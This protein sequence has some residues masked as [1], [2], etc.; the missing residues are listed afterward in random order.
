M[1]CTAYATRSRGDS[2]SG[3]RVITA[4]SVVALGSSPRPTTRVRR[5]RSVKM[6]VSLPAASTTRTAAW[7][8]W[9]MRWA[10]SLTVADSRRHTGSAGERM[11]TVSLN[12]A[13]L[14]AC[15][16]RLS[17]W[18][19]SSASCSYMLHL[20]P[21]RRAAAAYSP[22]N[23]CAFPMC[24]HAHAWT[25]PRIWRMWFRSWWTHSW[26]RSSTRSQPT[27]GCW[28]PRARSPGLSPRTRL[29]LS[30]R[31]RS[32]SATS[33]A[34]GFMSS[35]RPR[36][37]SFWSHPS[38]CAS[39]VVMSVLMRPAKPRRSASMMW[40]ITSL[41]D[42]SASPG[43]NVVTAGGRAETSA[44]M[45]ATALSSSAATSAVERRSAMSLHDL[46]RAELCDVR[47]G[48]AE[49][50]QDLVRVLAHI[51]G[52]RAHGGGRARQGGGRPL[53]PHLAEGVMLHGDG[54][55]EMLHLL[56]LERLLDVQNG[57]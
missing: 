26:R 2:T 29:T 11:L 32:S 35:R 31:M 38:S 22:E 49:L 24:G 55:A 23:F 47:R 7:R 43:W 17:L 57:T 9:S 39:L 12:T 19:S 1:Q 27:L 28:P 10:A 40:P 52:G 8:A 54:E 44:R 15:S 48:E 16:S 56:V 25:L 20:P 13:E 3:S 14:M 42:H 51:G 4:D 30:A 45:V 41:I 33:L 37:T 46:V 50:A 53:Q 5:S 6:P 36:A 21:A 34:A 18:Y